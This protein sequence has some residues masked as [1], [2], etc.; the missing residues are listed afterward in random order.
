MGS[1]CLGGVGQALVGGGVEHGVEIGGVVRGQLEQPGGVGVL[2]DRFRRI[3][4]GLVDFADRA[5]DRGIDVGGG[6]D[7]FDDGDFLLGI[8][9]GTDFRQFDED[10]VAEGFLGV[11]GD[12]DGDG[13]VSVEQH[14]FV[15]GGVLEVG[16]NVRHGFLLNG[17]N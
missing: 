16:G 15:G 10:E 17:G 5:R 3:G 7:R 6:L 13:A 9:M 2:V 4:G 11:V 12:A 8:E 14:P 1:P